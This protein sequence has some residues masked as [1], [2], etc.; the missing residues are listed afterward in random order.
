MTDDERF[1]VVNDDV[2]VRM[3]EPPLEVSER[4]LRFTADLIMD[5]ATVAVYALIIQRPVPEFPERMTAY[6]QFVPVRIS[7]ETLFALLERSVPAV[8]ELIAPI[9]EDGE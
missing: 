2:R 4:E 6:H 9:L 7:A 1:V 8:E 5:P 3:A